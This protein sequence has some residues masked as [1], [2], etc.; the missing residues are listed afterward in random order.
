MEYGLIGEHLGHSFSKEIHNKIGDY[1]YELKEIAPEDLDAFMKAK[2]F[3]GINVTIPY[4][5]KVIPYLDDISEGARKIGAVNCIVNRDGR[6]YGY[7]TDFDGMKALILRNNISLAGKKVLILGTGGTSKTAHAVAESLGAGEILTVSRRKSEGYITYEEAESV[8]SDASVIINTTPAGMYPNTDGKPTE[9][10]KYKSLTGVIDV[11]YNPLR[12][13]LVM[14]ASSMNIP[15]EGGLYMLVMQAVIASEYFFDT[16]YDKSRCD[17]IFNE[18]LAGKENIVLIGMPA[19]GKSSV[20]RRLSTRT[21]REYIDSDPEIEKK[22]G[23]TIPE[24]FEEHGETYFRDLESEVIKELSQ[25]SGI[26]ISTGGGAVLRMENVNNLKMNGRIF[27]IDRP[28][29]YLMPTDDR[30]LANSKDKIIKL[31]NERYPIYT[32]RC[33]VRIDVKG[34]VDWTTREIIKKSKEEK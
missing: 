12:T 4:K 27:F 23:K 13:K 24:I 29:K 19:C 5:E 21:G 2:N 3:M 14:E 28:L 25:K 17:S 26:I 10:S 33:D 9:I 1:N 20:G 18:I 22:A 15:S 16:K 30:P 7:N 6:L 31:Y 32:E 8:H 11:I 34:N